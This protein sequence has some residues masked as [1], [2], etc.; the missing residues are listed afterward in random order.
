MRKSISKSEFYNSLII[1][2]SNSILFFGFFLHIFYYPNNLIYCTWLSYLFNSFYLFI[3]LI[4]DINL[5]IFKSSNLEFINDFFR[6]KFSIPMNVVSY[7]VFFIY[8]VFYFTAGVNKIEGIFDFLKSFYHHILIMIIEIFDIF[9]SYHRYLKFSLKDLFICLITIN[10]YGIEL[11]VLIF[12]YNIPPYKFYENC[13]YMKFFVS[14]FIINI[15]IVIFYF[16]HLWLYK[17]KFKNEKNVKLNE[18]HEKSK[19]E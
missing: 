8:W 12:H 10:L 4:C 5:Y 17:L 16:F 6:N 19:N 3:S 2:G 7:Y 14:G 15:L 18:I 11:F 1:N 13:D 9:N